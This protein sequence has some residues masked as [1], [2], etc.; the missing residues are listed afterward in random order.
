MGVRQVGARVHRAEDEALIRGL[1]QYVD[2]IKLP[3]MLHAA[4]LR[5]EQAHALLR[6]IDASGARALP[7][8]HAVLTWADLPEPMRKPMVQ[9][10]PAPA[11]LQNLTPTPLAR[12]EV[13]HVGQAVAMVVADSRAIAEDA[14]A[15]IAVD[16]EPLPVI[17]DIRRA[18]EP[19]APRAHKDAPDN[20]AA[21]LAARFGD[22]EP[23]FA[24]A[25]STVQIADWQHRG[26]CHAMECRGVIAQAMPAT[27][28]MTVWSSTQCPYL[29]RRALAE[30]FGLAETSIR[31]IAPDVGGGFGPKAGFY[32]EEIMVMEAARQMGRPVK[33]IED[34]REHFVATTGQRDSY[35]ALEAA[36]DAGGRITAMRGHAI[37]DQGAFTPY[38]LLLPFT[39]IAPL[40][41]PYAI[42][43]VD[44]ELLVVH[45]NTTPNAPV[46]GA[47][48]PNAAYAME[49]LIEAVARKTGLA[50]QEVRRRNYVGKDAFPYATGAKNRTGAPA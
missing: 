10:Y 22:V 27:G 35:W 1:G 48:R 4:F 38:G 41:G 50:P 30:Q 19:D 26:G 49:R 34:R 46:R 23:A 31:V 7:G 24:Q 11:L 18:A 12:D 5:A 21:R 6:G 36:V 39:M 28:E 13:H 8:V 9:T 15:L 3:G 17:V 37:S 29:I 16:Y 33:W 25:H 42:R 32:V 40:P 47:G 43:N 2:D 14:L 44:V 20:I 45:T